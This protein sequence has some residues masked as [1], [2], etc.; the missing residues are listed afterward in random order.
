MKKGSKSFGIDVNALSREILLSAEA[1]GI[2]ENLDYF[3][4]QAQALIVQKDGF[5]LARLLLKVRKQQLEKHLEL[6]DK[7]KDIVQAYLDTEFVSMSMS[8]IPNLSDTQMISR[9][10][11][12][13][14]KEMINIRHKKAMLKERIG[15]IDSMLEKMP[16]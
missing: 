7:E 16:E 11:K 15:E 8:I 14:N 3:Q 13:F 10:E 5:G 4:Q 2:P 6:V 12:G 9:A 1:T